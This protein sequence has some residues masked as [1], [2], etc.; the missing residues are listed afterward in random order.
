MARTSPTAYLLLIAAVLLGSVLL[1]M[2]TPEVPVAEPSPLM[3]WGL[4]AFMLA[5]AI[6][7]MCGME[8]YARW[9]HRELWHGPALWAVHKTHHGERYKGAGLGLFELNDVFGI[10]NALAVIPIMAVAAA[11]TP[12]VGSVWAYGMTVGI[13]I[14]GTA[15]M[16]VHDGVHHRRFPTFGIEKIAVIERI[17]KAHALH[18]VKERAQPFGLFLGPQELECLAAGTVLPGPPTILRAGLLL[19]TALGLAGLVG[20]W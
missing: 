2:R 9:S 5:T 7:Y 11:C 12:T 19:T 10:G 4:R 1:M 17:S 8:F 18:H 15:Y 6:A 13:S 14:F 16:F 3:L 20:G